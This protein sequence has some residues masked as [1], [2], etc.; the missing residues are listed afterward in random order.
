VCAGEEDGLPQAGVISLTVGMLLYPNLR[1]LI[2]KT[3]RDDFRGIPATVLHS[4]LFALVLIPG[5]VAFWGTRPFDEAL[6][7]TT[8]AAESRADV[9]GYLLGQT[10]DDA[11]IGDSSGSDRRVT[12][13][14]TSEISRLVIGLKAIDEATCY[15]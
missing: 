15:A 14:P 9:R 7:C 6:L 4:M 10:T 11:F 2:A 1:G 12:S 3:F 13:I 5:C 8:S